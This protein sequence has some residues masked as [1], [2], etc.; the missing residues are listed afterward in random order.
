MYLAESFRDLLRED[1]KTVLI[2][3]RAAGQKQIRISSNI[4]RMF[5]IL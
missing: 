5:V 4:P 1:K 3:P 2:I